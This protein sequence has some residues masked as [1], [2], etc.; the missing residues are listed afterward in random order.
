MYNRAEEFNKRTSDYINGLTIMKGAKNFQSSF[1][2]RA[3][4]IYLTSWYN[5]QVE[6]LDFDTSGK[7]LR[8]KLKGFKNERPFNP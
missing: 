8:I 5:D 3:L 7:N 2:E 4:Y 1:V 6:L